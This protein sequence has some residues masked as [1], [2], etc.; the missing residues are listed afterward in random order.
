MIQVA[1][2]YPY[3]IDMAQVYLK[4]AKAMDKSFQFQTVI[5][6]VLGSSFLCPTAPVLSHWRVHISSRWLGI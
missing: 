3:E 5:K 4:I 2:A 1:V 6:V